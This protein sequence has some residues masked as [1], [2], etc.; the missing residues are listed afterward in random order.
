VNGW[1]AHFR[2][3]WEQGSAKSQFSALAERRW[4]A[5]ARSV[6]AFTAP[7]AQQQRCG[8]AAW[9]PRFQA[10]TFE[11]VARCGLG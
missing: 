4:F 7:H 9:S 3:L 1:R 2:D 6:L 5:L 8:S 10:S 11:K